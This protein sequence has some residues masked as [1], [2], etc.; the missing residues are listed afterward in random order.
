MVFFA[1]YC[2]FFFS[3]LVTAEIGTKV[4]WESEDCDLSQVSQSFKEQFF[5]TKAL[6]QER[7][8]LI[9]PAT[10]KCF[11]NPDSTYKFCLIAES[12]NRRNKACTEVKTPENLDVN[13]V[14]LEVNKTSLPF[15]DLTISREVENA[16]KYYFYLQMPQEKNH[17]IIL[18]LSHD[19][20]TLKDVMLPPGSGLI[21]SA[22]ICSE[23]V[24]EEIPSITIDVPSR[25][26]S[27][28]ELRTRLEDIRAL[29]TDEKYLDVISEFQ[30]LLSISKS[31]G[32]WEQQKNGVCGAFY[33]GIITAMNDLASQNFTTESIFEA[34]VILDALDESPCHFDNEVI[35]ENRTRALDAA[36][37]L[38]AN[39]DEAKK[40]QMA[41]NIEKFES[42]F[43]Q[44]RKI[45]K[46]ESTKSALD[47]SAILDDLLKK[48]L[49]D[50]KN[51]ERKMKIFQN[52]VTNLS[53]SDVD[54]CADLREKLTFEAA[55]EAAQGITAQ[56]P[57]VELNIESLSMKITR[58]YPKVLEN[59]TSLFP[60]EAY[61][62][63]SFLA[64]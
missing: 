53:S 19:E 29:L 4:R 18:G 36:T 39:M 42:G 55:L 44:P 58:D 48:E 23:N 56:D 38:L 11:N 31:G 47:F 16:L 33:R 21:L 1:N 51:L 62:R 43:R 26:I 64:F 17:Q 25:M 24:C 10:Q 34:N 5:Q 37:E 8:Y 52:L 27:E 2:N 41:T 54:R 15:V 28:E 61:S 40:L 3:A 30:T 49:F 22:K 45:F 32:K 9:I 50:P 63:V 12:N 35:S 46:R 60:D 20:P 6:N 7:F 13:G 57:P 59:M 14:T